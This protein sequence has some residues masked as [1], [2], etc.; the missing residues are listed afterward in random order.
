[1]LRSLVFSTVIV[2]GLCWTTTRAQGAA[3]PTEQGVYT[4][5]NAKQIP[6]FPTKLAGFQPRPGEDYFGENFRSTGTVTV[7]EDDDW[8]FIE[9]FPYSGIDCIAG[10][11]TLRWQLSDPA[12]KIRTAIENP[13]NKPPP[14]MPTGSFGYMYGSSC[15]QPR[16]KFVS[17]TGKNKA[18]S[19]DVL[20]EIRFWK[21]A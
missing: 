20:Y 12:V 17:S 21:T 7:D 16:F 19:I 6:A 8:Q 4:S 2:L 18:T 11:Y 15:T 10:V 9:D 14:P 13:G 3:W 5:S 1:M